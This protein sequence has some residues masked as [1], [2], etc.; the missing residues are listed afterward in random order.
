MS[1]KFKIKRSL[2]GTL[3][4]PWKYQGTPL[5]AGLG[6]ETLTLVWS[7]EANEI[8]WGRMPILPPSLKF[9]KCVCCGEGGESYTYP[10]SY[11]IPA[12]CPYNSSQFW[13]CRPGDSW[14][15]DPT[16]SEAVLKYR[17]L[18]G[19]LTD[20]LWSAHN[21]LLGP[22]IC[23]NG[24]TQRNVLLMEKMHRARCGKREYSFHA[25]PT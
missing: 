19:L 20:R 22:L 18:P 4:L 12:G 8:T 23:W 9:P 24:S 2:Q 21:L 13:P 6:S 5:P 17:L 16:F 25:L 7:R 3:A 1:R 14:G 10:N 15:L 11:G